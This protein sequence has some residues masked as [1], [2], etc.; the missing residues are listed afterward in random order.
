MGLLAPVLHLPGPGA[1]KELL[2]VQD[3]RAGLDPFPTPHHTPEASHPG[4]GRGNSDSTAVMLTNEESCSESSSSP[5]VLLEEDRT[6]IR[7]V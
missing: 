3:E 5:F 4:R 6:A 7:N 2:A 1:S